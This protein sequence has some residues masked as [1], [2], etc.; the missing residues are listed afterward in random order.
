MTPQKQQDIRCVASRIRRILK[1]TEGMPM[2]TMF[3]EDVDTLLKLILEED[4]SE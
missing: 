3:W 2:Q 4:K 1:G